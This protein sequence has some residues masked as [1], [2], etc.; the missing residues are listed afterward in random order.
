MKTT[1]SPIVLL[2]KSSLFELSNDMMNGVYDYA[3]QHGWQMQLIEHG[4]AFMDTWENAPQ[5][6]PADVVRQSLAFW[7]PVGCL[8]NSGPDPSPTCRRC[9]MGCRRSSWTFLQET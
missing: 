4:A 3:R 6:S 7:H 8:W 9:S 1:R 5:K 2:F